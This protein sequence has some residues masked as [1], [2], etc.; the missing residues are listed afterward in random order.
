MAA[1]TTPNDANADNFQAQRR[2]YDGF[3]NV[4]KWSTLVVVII[5]AIV[6]LIIA[7]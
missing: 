1:D 2:N 3:I 4:T 5:T 6:V 7:S